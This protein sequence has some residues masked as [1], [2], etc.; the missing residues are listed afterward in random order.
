[1]R[2]TKQL[3]HAAPLCGLALTLAAPALGAQQTMS[4]T[5]VTAAS[6]SEAHALHERGEA[7]RTSTMRKKDMKRAA[8]MHLRAAELRGEEAAD[9]YT[10]L[11]TAAML[12]YGAGDDGK[13]AE[14]LERAAEQAANRGDVV[15][16]ASAFLDASSLASTMSQPERAV[17]LGRRAES[18]STSPLL[19]TAQRASLR[20]R[21]VGAREIA[22][23]R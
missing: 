13:A 19:S 5:V 23:V 20:A 12:Y 14:L 21:M 2:I 11:W 6:L 15:N 18:L 8:K 7:L 17:R 16:A 3:R 4:P 10:C 22:S 9:S 1:M